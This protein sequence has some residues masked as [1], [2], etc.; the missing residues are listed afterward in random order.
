MQQQILILTIAVMA[1]VAY[2]FWRVVR[3]SQHAPQPPSPAGRIE[4][5]RTALLASLAVTGLVVAVATLRPWPHD[6]HAAPG[7][8]IVRA[9]GYQWYWEL[10]TEE[11]TAGR[12]VVFE[13]ASADVNHGFGVYDP[14]GTILFQ[15][16][17]M[18]GYVNKVKHTFTE[19]GTYRVLCLEYCGT[20]HHDMIGEFKVVAAR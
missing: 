8:Q 17:V 15:T 11:V 2:P 1:L 14:S 10:D 13:V 3:T 12:P 4:R 19:P 6:A 9:V 20:A 5:M 18:P 16:Q 7:A